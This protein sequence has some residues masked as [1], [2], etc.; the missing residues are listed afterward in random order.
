M[1]SVLIFRCGVCLGEFFYI[2][3]DILIPANTVIIVL[4]SYTVK[5]YATSQTLDNLY[6]SP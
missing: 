4:F 6:F 3:I 5:N 2:N 1:S